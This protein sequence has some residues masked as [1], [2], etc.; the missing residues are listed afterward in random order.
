MHVKLTEPV[1]KNL[2]APEKGQKIYW[3]SELKGFGLRATA[4]GAKAFILNYRTKEG[5]EGRYLIGRPQ[6]GTPA[7]LWNLPVVETTAMAQNTFLTGAFSLGAQIFDRMA[8]EILIS[9]ENDKDFENNMVTI[10]A[11]E[12]LAQRDARVVQN[13]LGG[14][15]LASS[16]VRALHALHMAIR[17]SSR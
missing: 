17:L 4:G 13:H 12:R 14:Q 8:V 7:R 2:T 1:V 3:D 10:R 6:D 16:K 9:T 15:K 11:E 5:R